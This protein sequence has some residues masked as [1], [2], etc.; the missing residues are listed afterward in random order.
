M[1]TINISG[2]FE[3]A[4]SFL[5]KATRVSSITSNAASDVGS[6][7]KSEV[8]DLTPVDTG[9]TAR[10]WF[11]KI[12]SEGSLVRISL[13]NSNATSIGVPI[14]ILL[15]YGHR[16]KSGRFVAGHDFVTP[17]FNKRVIDIVKRIR[18]EVHK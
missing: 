2:R 10:S 15:M 12:N 18:E 14:P 9:E 8:A 4:T 5:R 17:T 1:I 11:V 3:K 16:T 13:N 6:T 7:I